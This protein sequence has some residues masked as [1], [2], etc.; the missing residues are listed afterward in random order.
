MSDGT[1]H[2]NCNF[3]TVNVVSIV[4]T[5]FMA[6]FALLQSARCGLIFTIRGYTRS[7]TGYLGHIGFRFSIISSLNTPIAT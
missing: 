1:P 4:I 7:Y 2:D 3:A 5:Y 6:S